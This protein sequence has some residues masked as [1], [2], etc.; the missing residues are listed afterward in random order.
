MHHPILQALY[1][2]RPTW[3]KGSV[4]EMGYCLLIALPIILV[5]TWLFSLAFERPFM[6]KKAGKRQVDRVDIYTPVSLPLRT[7]GATR[8]YAVVMMDEEVSEPS[9]V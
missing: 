7:L 5:G 6:S 2:Y 9:P 1:V 3:V 4:V 8:T